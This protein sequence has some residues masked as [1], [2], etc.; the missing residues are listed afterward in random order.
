M[1]LNQEKQIT[2]ETIFVEKYLE[3][4]IIAKLFGQLEK[5]INGLPQTLNKYNL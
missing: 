1:L 3:S 5:K 2:L 4:K